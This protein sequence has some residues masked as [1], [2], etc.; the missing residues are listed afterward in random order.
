MPIA[1]DIQGI[2]A[3]LPHRYPMLLVDGVLVLDPDAKRIVA[4]KNVTINEPQFTGHW[5]ENPVMPGVLILEAL[6]QTGALLLLADPANQDKLP[7]LTGADNVKWR[8]K[9]VPGDQLTLEVI[10]VRRKGDFIL[11]EAKASINDK[12]VCEG[13]ITCCLT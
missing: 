13:T 11:G 6:A 5:P 1:M 7:V 4:F 9:V 3:R 8:G 10:F 12:V 2:L